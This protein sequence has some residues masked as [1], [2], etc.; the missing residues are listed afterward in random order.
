VGFEHAKVKK[1]IT[2]DRRSDFKEAT[3]GK[4]GVARQKI[5]TRLRGKRAGHLFILLTLFP[6]SLL[7]H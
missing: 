2:K 7:P 5:N 1:T 6:A 4:Y 3:Q